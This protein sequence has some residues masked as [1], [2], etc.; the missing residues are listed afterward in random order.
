MKFKTEI[1]KLITQLPYFGEIYKQS[2][3]SLYPNGHYHSPVF[4]IDDIKKKRNPNM[5]KRN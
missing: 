3:N 2:L 5:G 1:K 4:S